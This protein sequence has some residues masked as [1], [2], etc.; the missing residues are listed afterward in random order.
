MGKERRSKNGG[1]E[2]EIVLEYSQKMRI[3]QKLLLAVMK[4]RSKQVS[5]IK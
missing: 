3:V 4:V 2:V 1:D 5:N